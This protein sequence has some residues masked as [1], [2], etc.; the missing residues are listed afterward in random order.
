MDSY[1][2]LEELVIKMVSH[3][4]QEAIKEAMLKREGFNVV[5]SG[6]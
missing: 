1:H 3:E 4:R 5:G 2:P 6:E